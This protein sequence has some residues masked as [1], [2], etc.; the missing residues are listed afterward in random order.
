[1]MSWV[2]SLVWVIQHA[3]W[4]GCCSRAAE[5]REHRLGTVARLLRELREIDGAA[6][7]ARRRSG[8]EAP[9]R[10]PE[11]AQARRQRERRRIARAAG[12]VAREADVDQPTEEC[13]GGEHHG[14]RVEAQADGRDG[15][16]DPLA[17]DD[18]VIDR[19]LEDA[20][21]GLRLEATPDGGPI[22]DAV[23]LGARGP[24]RG[25]LAA[26]E[27]AELDAGLVRGGRHGAAQRVDLLHQVAFADPA[28]GRVAGHLAEGFDRVGEQQRARAGARGSQRRLGAGMAATHDEDV[29]TIGE[30]HRKYA[31]ASQT[32][33]L[34]ESGF[35]PHRFHVEQPGARPT[36]HVEHH[37]PMQNRPKI[38]PRRS[39]A[40][41]APVMRPSSRWASRSSSACKSKACL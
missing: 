15:A 38:S 12:L 37:L 24:D 28:D 32:G 6:V 19:G 27:R 18:Q 20:Q 33:I 4:R 23:G 3:T 11:L 14:R 41:T 2:R 21:V 5:E 25:P 22:E 29:E 39:S 9:G 35:S 30:I 31:A 34:R 1:M 36:F 26:I 17:L 10:E 40:L 8:L 13:P 16:R 7:D